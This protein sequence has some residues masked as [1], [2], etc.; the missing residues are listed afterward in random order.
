MAV[1][2]MT[3]LQLVNMVIQESG[4]EL[5]ELDSSTFTSTTN[6][7]HKRIKNWVKQAWIDIQNQHDWDWMRKDALVA[8]Y[9]RWKV[10]ALTASTPVADYV[11]IGDDTDGEITYVSSAAESGTFAAGTFV[12]YVNYT[13]PDGSLKLGEVLDLYESDGTTLSTANAA[14]VTG[15]GAYNLRT[16]VSDL[17]VPLHNT[18][19]YLT[20]TTQTHSAGVADGITTPTKLHYVPSLAEYHLLYP[21]YADSPDG[22]SPRFLVNVGAG[23]YDLLPR[24]TVPLNLR[25]RYEAEPQELSLHSDTL[26]NMPAEFGDVVA[27]RALMYYSKFS[28]KKSS[29]YYAKDRHGDKWSTLLLRHAPTVTFGKN[30]YGSR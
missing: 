15:Y 30:K 3:Y 8:I 24:P 25:F 27:W 20:P 10:T 26:T 21:Q 9:P 4:A 11:L 18:F 19:S 22:A 23:Y 14:Q 29:Y 12:G 13:D 2:A 7:L 17:A 6:P 1:T 16:L 28:S 5:L